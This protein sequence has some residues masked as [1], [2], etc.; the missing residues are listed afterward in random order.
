[1]CF[2]YLGLHMIPMISIVVDCRIY[3][4][5]ID[6]FI[7]CYLIW[8][9]SYLSSISHV[10]RTAACLVPATSRDTHITA[11]DSV[12][13]QDFTQCS[14][15]SDRRDGT[16]LLFLVRRVCLFLS[17]FLS[18]HSLVLTSELVHFLFL[19][20]CQA[21]DFNL[22]SFGHLLLKLNLPTSCWYHG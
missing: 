5:Y 17:H 19:V 4:Q 18:S 21:S 20:S 1:M 14:F 8:F 10:G 7:H 11:R 16:T 3:L 13:L 22:S 6:L 12:A 2:R 9:C 15:S